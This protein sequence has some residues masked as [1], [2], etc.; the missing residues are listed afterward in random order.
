MTNHSGIIK[1]GIGQPRCFIRANA[2]KG[3]NKGKIKAQDITEQLKS[4]DQIPQVGAMDNIHSVVEETV[5]Q[6]IIFTKTLFLCL[7]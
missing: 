4:E 6:A 5:R 7:T 2:I 3:T 1:H